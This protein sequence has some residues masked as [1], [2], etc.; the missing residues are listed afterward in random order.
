MQTQAAKPPEA[1]TFQRSYQGQ[2]SHVRRVRADLAPFAEGC[3][4]A[5]DLILAAS[6]L[7]TNAIMHSR[8]GK[9]GGKFTVRVSLYEGH[10]AWLEVEDLGGPWITREHDDK[11]PHGLEIVTRLAGPGNW[12]TKDTGLGNRIVWVRLAWTDVA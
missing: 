1:T 10:Y 5:D 6:E 7:A 11:H 12:G 8:S 3:P 9:P 4:R 2:P